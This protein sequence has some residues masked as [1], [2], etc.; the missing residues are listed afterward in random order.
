MQPAKQAVPLCGHSK[1]AAT[2]GCARLDSPRLARPSG[3]LRESASA[4]L[5]RL[6]RERP[7]PARRA[8]HP[9][10]S[11]SNADLKIVLTGPNPG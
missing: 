9:S 4:A 7:L 1:R 10:L 11:R 6:A 5:R 3:L 2:K 8:L